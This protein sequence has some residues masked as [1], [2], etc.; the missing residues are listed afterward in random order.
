MISTS[1]LCMLVLLLLELYVLSGGT[2]GSNREN[3][4]KAMHSVKN[5]PRTPTGNATFNKILKS[6]LPFRLFLFQEGFARAAKFYFIKDEFV[7]KI[8]ESH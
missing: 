8:L 6:I 2:T 4:L 7:M 5:F 1:A 3:S